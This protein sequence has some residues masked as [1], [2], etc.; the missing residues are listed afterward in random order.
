MEG[1]DGDADEAEGGVADGGGH[2]AD[3]AVLSFC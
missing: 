2:A 3:L 1:T